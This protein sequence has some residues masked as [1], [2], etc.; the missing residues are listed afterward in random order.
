[1]SAPGENP[2]L[3]TESGIIQLF[4]FT[5][6]ATVPSS[7][8]FTF[9]DLDLVTGP[10]MCLGTGGLNT[11]YECPLLVTECKMILP[12]CMTDTLTC[13]TDMI[14]LLSEAMLAYA[15]YHAGPVWPA[16][17]PPGWRPCWGLYRQ[18]RHHGAAWGPVGHEQSGAACLDSQWLKNLSVSH[19]VQDPGSAWLLV[20]A[21]HLQ[22]THNI[23]SEMFAI[24]II[25]SNFS[26]LGTFPKAT[27]CSI[28]QALGYSTFFVIWLN[29]MVAGTAMVLEQTCTNFSGKSPETW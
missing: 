13:L 8:N 19:T 9:S 14:S 12:H 29:M 11:H 18:P 26:R 6:T 20:W 1:M 28:L 4:R 10:W 25:L 17:G 23:C 5:D 22:M 21:T 27:W 15:A 2:T 7:T 3:S 16:S 24:F